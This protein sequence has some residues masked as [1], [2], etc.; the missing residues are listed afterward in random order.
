M[1]SVIF[2]DTNKRQRKGV[3]AA[4]TTLNKTAKPVSKNEISPSTRMMDAIIARRLVESTLVS[5][6]RVA[7][8][9]LRI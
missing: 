5:R 3:H 6:K 8:I 1:Q 7:S 4:I 2:V 9:Q